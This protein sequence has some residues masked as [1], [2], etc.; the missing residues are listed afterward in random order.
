VRQSLLDIATFDS[1]L[2]LLNTLFSGAVNEHHAKKKGSA[3]LDNLKTINVRHQT[4]TRSCHFLAVTLFFV[5]L[6]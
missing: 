3:W 4:Q 5:S 6:E 1:F 2:I